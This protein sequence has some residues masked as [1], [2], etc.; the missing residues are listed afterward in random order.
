MVIYNTDSSKAVMSEDVADYYIAA[1][2][3][4]PAH[5]LGIDLGSAIRLDPGY[6]GDPADPCGNLFP[7]A[8]AIADFFI[9]NDI[10]SI[11]WSAG[12][13]KYA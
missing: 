13:R 9:A 10:E 5:K 11:I 2:G 6:S 3:L 1:R 12:T 8:D 4:N 7:I